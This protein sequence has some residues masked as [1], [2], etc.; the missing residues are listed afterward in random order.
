MSKIRSELGWS[1][2]EAYE[3]GLP[4]D[5]QPVVR[6]EP[7]ARLGGPPLVGRTAEWAR[8]VEL[9]RETELGR[10]HFVLVAGE[11]GI[12]KTRLVEE[13]RSWVVRRGAIAAEAELKR[14][15]ITPPPGR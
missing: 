7:S 12:G 11:P 1:T 5:E 15:G 8:L 9:W 3:A 6:A 14:L 4:V 10:A 13:F 2:R